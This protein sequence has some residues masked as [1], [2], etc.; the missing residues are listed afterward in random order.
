MNN[1]NDIVIAKADSGATANYWREE[2]MKCL[3]N[4][5]HVIG[6]SVQLPNGNS[7]Q[8]N[9]EGYLHLSKD[10]NTVK[11]KVTILPELKSASLLSLGKLCDDNCNIFLDKNSMKVTKN[12]K[13]ILTGIRNANDGLW[14]VPFRKHPNPKASIQVNYVLPKTHNIYPKRQLKSSLNITKNI[15]P[16]IHVLYILYIYI[17]YEMVCPCC[18]AARLGRIVYYKHQRY[19]WGS[20]IK[21]SGHA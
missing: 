12:N 9:Q 2:D 7:I 1:T 19:I 17:I 20:P 8:A 6:P 5:K 15:H 4:V 21:Q 3:T 14:D 13:C 11:K 10:L 16:C 18:G